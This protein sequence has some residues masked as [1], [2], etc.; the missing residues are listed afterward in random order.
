MSADCPSDKQEIES[1]RQRIQVLED[2]KYE[3]DLIKERLQVLEEQRHGNLNL[4]VRVSE[5]EEAMERSKEEFGQEIKASYRNLTRAWHSIGELTQRNEHLEKRIQASEE[6][7]RRLA[8]RQ[9]E[10]VDVDISLEERVEELEGILDEEAG[11]KKTHRERGRS[12]SAINSIPTSASL[13]PERRAEA[14]TS[15]A[16]PANHDPL[17]N[18]TI[19]PLRPAPTSASIHAGS[20]SW[21]VHV[22]LMPTATR[23][24]PFERDTVAYKRCLSRGLHQMVAIT[25]YDDESFVTAVS[26]AFKNLLLDRP[27]APLQAELCNAES[28][29]G[30]PMLRQLDATLVGRKYD[31][32]FLRR[33]CA[34]HDARGRIDSLYIALRD[35]SLSWNFLRHAP[36]FVTGLEACWEYTPLLDGNDLFD[37]DDEPGNPSRPS[38]GE[39]I[40]VLPPSLKRAAS[41]MSRSS[42]FGSTVTSKLTDGEGPSAKAPCLINVAEV[43]SRRAETV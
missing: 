23:P 16:W 26:K 13:M 28:L 24:F 35:D 38:A 36:V 20:F 37:D 1:L 19:I 31:F 7:Q 5:L 22:S 34:V 14:S 15:L 11:K 25:G 43:S 27:W 17:S 10:L 41:E 33:Y 40:Q 18:S 4:L 2:E 39:I 12:K 29:Q 21:T 42:S 3:R 32:E 9:L 8:Q 6:E 30:L